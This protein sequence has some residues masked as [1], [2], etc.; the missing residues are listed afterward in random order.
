MSHILLFSVIAVLAPSLSGLAGV[1]DGEPATAAVL[2]DPAGPVDLDTQ[3]L[4]P[5]DAL[6]CWRRIGRNA[7]QIGEHFTMTVTCRVIETDAARTVPDEAALQPQ[8]ID[9]APFE[10]LDG[11][12]Y[13]DVQD[14]V[15][16]LFQFHYTLR[17]IG[18][19][20]FG[21]D[22]E[23]PPLE[24]HYHIDRMLDASAVRPGRE[25]TYVLP[26]ESIRIL[27]L[28]PAQIE[29]IRD[30]GV[31][32]FGAAEART[33]FA[34]AA[35]LAAGVLGILALGLLVVGVMRAR[36]ERRAAV[37]SRDQPAPAVAIA[38]R[39]L[40]ELSVVQQESQATGW[41]GD[42]AGRALSAF[43]LAGAVALSLPVAQEVVESGT[44]PHDG[45][46]TLRRGFWRPKTLAVSSALTPNTVADELDRKQVDQPGHLLLAQLDGIRRALALFTTARYS[47]NGD[48]PTDELTRE[49]DHGMTLVRQVQ[50]HARTPV[51]QLERLSNSVRLWWHQRWAS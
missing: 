28:V 23:I 12:R 1:L 14:D 2:Q 18:E 43:R 21:T 40:G 45:Q 41:D 8:S 50:F 37:D 15:G 6:R 24:L 35:M 17:V 36:H 22:V 3:E 33:F 20:Y 39:A 19:D 13:S 26:A 31:E 34:N 7:V 32:T 30:V 29:D 49:L 47:R 38:R 4:Q 9:V 27:S 11:Q 46:L 48:L 5:V 51:R 44:R 16:R 10:V 42:L 25:M